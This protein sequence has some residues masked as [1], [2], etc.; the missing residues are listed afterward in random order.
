MLI[1]LLFSL[2]LKL[3]FCVNEYVSFAECM[4]DIRGVL[5][6]RE[7]QF[8]KH[9]SNLLTSRNP[10]SPFK[11]YGGRAAFFF[12][13]L[14]FVVFSFLN[15]PGPSKKKNDL[16]P[17]SFVYSPCDP[18]TTI[19][20][21]GLLSSRFPLGPSPSIISGEGVCALNQASESGWGRGK[22]IGNPSVIHKVMVVKVPLESMAELFIIHSFWFYRHS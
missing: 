7:M 21:H 3:L 2:F 13:P 18:K 8:K 1:Y 11:W 20:A 12:V 19:L 22:L 6:C 4:S 5:G 9:C 10:P 14:Y 15:K 17:Y 16:R